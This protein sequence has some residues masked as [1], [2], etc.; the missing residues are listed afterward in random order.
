MSQG[1]DPFQEYTYTAFPAAL[2][3]RFLDT[4]VA[5]F[6]P[7]FREALDLGCGSGGLLEELRRLEPGARLTGVDVSA[8]CIEACRERASLAGEGVSLLQCDA[9]ELAGRDELRDRFDV[10]VS[11]SV[12]HL[13]PGDTPGK[14]RLLA[15][16]TRPGAVV[17]VDA[18]A[19]IPW[20]RFMFGL[21]RLLIAT[22]LWGVALRLL[23][24]VVGPSFPKAFLEELAGM[25]Y[26][27][28]LRY[29]D[30]LDLAQLRSEGFRRDFELL[31]LDVVPQDGFLTGRK[32]RLAL[33]RRT[34][35]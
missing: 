9:L 32:A 17:A 2:Y 34:G 6:A 25:K 22:G 3:R 11:Y 20:N 26:L 16:L 8:A 1:V 28:H 14:L 35:A 5:P 23:G 21:V 7:G 12:L 13:V 19:R 33:R 4:Y 30:F 18:L 10:L 29:A 15:Q 27:R 31:R 24:P